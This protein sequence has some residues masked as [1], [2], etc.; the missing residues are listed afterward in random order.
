MKTWLIALP[1]VCLFSAAV[2]DEVQ[3]DQAGTQA[4][5]RASA[6]K[7]RYGMH[8][9]MTNRRLPRGD[10]R[11]CLEQKTNEAIIRCSETGRKR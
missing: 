7:A 10:L 1:L 6:P 8:K 11:D 4:R 2:A 9:A 5:A 3:K